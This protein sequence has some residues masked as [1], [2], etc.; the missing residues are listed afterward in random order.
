MLGF[1]KKYAAVRGHEPRETEV[2]DTESIES[3]PTEKLVY[4]LPEGHS[5][6]RYLMVL[7]AV[8]MLALGAFTFYIGQ[9]AFETPRISLKETFHCG[10]S[11]A[12]AKVLGCEFDIL[13]YSWTP[14]QCL[15]TETRDEFREW[16]HSK[17]RLFRPWPFFADKDANDWIPN[18]E[19][20]SE[21]VHPQFSWAPIEEHVGHCMF[22]MRRLYRVLEGGGNLRLNSRQGT[23]GHVEHC[24]NMVLDMIREPKAV[25]EVNSHFAVTFSSC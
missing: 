10:N 9:M 14:K 24:S 3:A 12:E 16:L 21:R 15:D 4:L 17:D 6:R 25:G 19:T 22:M 11:T 1:Q 2:P 23:Y 20:L 7:L 8:F 13:S 5:R 18:E